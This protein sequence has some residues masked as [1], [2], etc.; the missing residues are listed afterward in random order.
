M[1]IQGFILKEKEI[2]VLFCLTTMIKIVCAIFRLNKIN[3]Y[4]TP[5]AFTINL[6]NIYRWDEK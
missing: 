6:T 5:K 3:G 4:W 2:S 1:A